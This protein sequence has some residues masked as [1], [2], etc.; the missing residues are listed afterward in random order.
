MADLHM[1]VVNAMTVL[2]LGHAGMAIFHHH[3]LRDGLLR[4]MTA[5]RQGWIRNGKTPPRRAA[6][7]FQHCRVRP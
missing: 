6:F 3:V 1:L 2:I 7:S 5:L 4:A